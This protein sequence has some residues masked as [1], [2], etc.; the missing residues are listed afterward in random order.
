MNI[1]RISISNGAIDRAPQSQGADDARNAEQSRSS[2]AD[3]AISLSSAAKDVE[4]ISDMV[5]QS[6]TDRFDQVRDAISKGTYRVSGADIAR[7]LIEFNE[8]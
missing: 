2:A 1:D 7:K 3:D 8:L 6:R 4:R 5:E